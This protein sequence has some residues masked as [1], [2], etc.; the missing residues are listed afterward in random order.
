MAEPAQTR[1][2]QHNGW[3]P[4]RQQCFLDALADSGSVAAAA[5]AAGMSRQSAY[6][7]RRHPDAGDFA[8]AWDLALAVAGRQIEE[9]ALDRII[10]GEAV[11]IVRDGRVVE[12]RRRPC[13]ARLLVAALKRLDDGRLA[14]N[15]VA[16]PADASPLSR[17]AAAIR[18]AGGTAGA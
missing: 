12:V 15:R 9:L 1:R 18:A 11:E 8:R 5:A 13:D 10:T 7:L 14:G 2:Q 6:R 16:H 17:L 3:T 4:Q